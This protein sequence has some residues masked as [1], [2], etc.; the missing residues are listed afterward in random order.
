MRGPSSHAFWVRFSTVLLALLGSAVSW[1]DPVTRVDENASGIY[2]EGSEA[3]TVE[4][5]RG[6]LSL[7]YSFR[8]PAA[9]GLAQPS[10]AL[11]YSSTTRAMPKPAMVG[12]SA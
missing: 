12:A 8:L 11:S 2:G 7:A 10:L 5:N 1:A 9:R 6:S 3:A 4:A